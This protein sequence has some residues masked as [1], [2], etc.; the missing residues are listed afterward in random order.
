MSSLV[1]TGALG[2]LM[3]VLAFV[4]LAGRG[5]FL[6]AG[7]NTLPKDQKAKYDAKALSKFIGK[8]LLPIGILTIFAGMERIVGWY[9]W[10]FVAVTIGLCLFA[11]IYVNTGNRFKK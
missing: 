5:S 6:I 3:I 11:V 10:V 4:L 7:F 2:G 9:P 1:I 8:I